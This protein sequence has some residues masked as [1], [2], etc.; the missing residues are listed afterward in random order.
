M[1]KTSKL[2]YFITN[3]HSTSG[4]NNFRFLPSN[5]SFSTKDQIFVFCLEWG[6]EVRK[7]KNFGFLPKIRYLDLTSQFKIFFTSREIL[8]KERNFGA[9]K[10]LVSFVEP[11]LH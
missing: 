6:I 5:E 10:I 7:T 1:V 8:S 11:F 3:G 9:W 2:Q 4:Q